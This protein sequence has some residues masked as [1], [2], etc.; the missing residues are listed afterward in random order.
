VRIIVLVTEEAS[1]VLAYERVRFSLLAMALS[2]HRFAPCPVSPILLIT[3]LFPAHDPDLVA[4]APPRVHNDL[5]EI[6]VAAV[7]SQ[8]GRA[9]GEV[10]LLVPLQHHLGAREPTLRLD[11]LE[12]IGPSP[13]NLQDV[14][15]PR[16]AGL[17]QN[18]KGRVIDP[19]DQG[20][21]PKTPG[22]DR[23]C[24]W[25]GGVGLSGRILAKGQCE[26]RRV[27]GLLLGYRGGAGSIGGKVELEGF[28]IRPAMSERGGATGGV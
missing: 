19:A 10:A 11:L 26:F 13:I 18:L 17:F 8:I 27:G 14:V 21:H 16:P 20:E 22:S 25:H 12:T 5:V 7:V 9:G 4:H 3:L 23:R 6:L 15:F 2:A 24:E 1:L 28:E